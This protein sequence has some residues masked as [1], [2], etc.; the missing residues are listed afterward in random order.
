[1]SPPRWFIL[2]YLK[3]RAKAEK[4]RQKA[5]SERDKRE[6]ETKRINAI[7]FAVEAV[8]AKWIS[9]LHA[10]T[11]QIITSI[12]TIRNQLETA[13]NQQN[14]SDQKKN[15][16]EKIALRVAT[17]TLIFVAAYTVLTYCTY[18]AALQTSVQ[19]HNDTLNAI[20]NAQMAEIDQHTDTIRS[21]IRTEVSNA[22]LL[23]QEK[24]QF[25]AYVTIPELFIK[26]DKST[27][28]VS[29]HVQFKNVGLTPAYEFTGWTCIYIG[30]FHQEKGV[31]QVETNFP[32]Q[33]FPESLLRPKTMV[34]PGA[35]KL[36]W[37][38][39]FCPE[40]INRPLTQ[41]EVTRLKSGYAAIYLYGRQTYT[42]A[43][44]DKR[45]I[46]F[47]VFNNDFLGLTSEGTTL[48]TSE[49]FQGN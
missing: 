36:S 1:M 41:E 6:E 35:V 33:K 23:D 44:G 11:N 45:W 28:V 49:G 25:R 8:A 2:N 38:T 10:A 19:Q 37:S 46:A 26:V 22:I 31:V 5:Q 30:R 40:G 42:D 18:D 7:T 14:A 21:L 20:T 47:H 27:N 32:Q 3:K 4:Q 48:D 39:F 9:A 16:R 24:R 43:F 13:V 17:L 12:N 34:G 29:T 15:R